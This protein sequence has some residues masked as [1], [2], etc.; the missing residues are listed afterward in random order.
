[1]LLFYINNTIKQELNYISYMIIHLAFHSHPP[2]H[3]VALRVDYNSVTPLIAQWLSHLQRA[4]HYY[5]IERA[6]S[7]HLWYSNCSVLCEGTVTQ[8]A[9]IHL[10]QWWHLPEICRISSLCSAG[11]QFHC[12]WTHKNGVSFNVDRTEAPSIAQNIWRCEHPASSIVSC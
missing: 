11:S 6:A 7:T 5:S 10:E 1:M 2:L 8:R 12:G 9:L 4:W 3:N